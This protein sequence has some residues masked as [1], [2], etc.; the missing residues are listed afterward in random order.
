MVSMMSDGDDLSFEIRRALMIFT[1]GG[2]R[3]LSEAQ[4]S[5]VSVLPCN[6]T[7]LSPAFAAVLLMTD[8][9]SSTK[10]PTVSTTPETAR[11]IFQEFARETLRGDFS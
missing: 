10:T 8:G 6:W 2:K 3:F 4:Y 7:R 9:S 11:V 5:G 1:S